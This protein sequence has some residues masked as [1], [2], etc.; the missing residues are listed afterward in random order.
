MAQVLV[1]EDDRHVRTMFREMLDAAGYDVLEAGD[2][3]E[4]VDIYSRQPT[5]VVITDLVMPRKH[6]FD[7]IRELKRDY[8]DVRI[9]AISGWGIH[10]LETAIAYG[11][12]RIYE[13]PVGRTELLGAVQELIGAGP[14]TPS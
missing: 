11:A 3:E 12:L 7:A 1:V 2:G 13:K 6:G 5:D 14:A 4:A 8:P 10:L 9:I